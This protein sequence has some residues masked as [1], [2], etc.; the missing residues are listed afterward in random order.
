MATHSSILAWRNHTDRGARWTTV[1]VVSKSQTRLK[2]ASYHLA[3][4]PSSFV[5]VQ[6]LSCVQLFADPVDC[7][8]PG[9]PAFTISRSLLLLKSTESLMPFNHH[10]LYHPL[11]LP[12]SVFPS[13]KISYPFYNQE[14]YHCFPQEPKPKLG[15]EFHKI[16]ALFLKST[17]IRGKS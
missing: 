16:L 3:H 1:H 9:F 5:V 14:K 7:S 8:M 4:Q 2:Q 15:E 12:P 6:S 11:L 13:M 10:I 17:V